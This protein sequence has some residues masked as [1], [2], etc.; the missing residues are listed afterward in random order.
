MRNNV[1]NGVA[2]PC[3]TVHDDID[4]DPHAGRSEGMT[5]D[6]WNDE[7]ET[8]CERDHC[9]FETMQGVRNLKCSD[10]V[11]VTESKC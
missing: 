9:S 8:N 7:K 11:D 4:V 6:I 1:V 2:S 10:V 5:T 3:G